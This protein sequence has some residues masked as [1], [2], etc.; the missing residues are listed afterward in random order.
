VEN[1]GIEVLCSRPKSV[2]IA[3]P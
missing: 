2:L 1:T 3:C